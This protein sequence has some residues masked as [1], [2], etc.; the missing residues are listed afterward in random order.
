MVLALKVC[1]LKQEFSTAEP[2][3]SYGVGLQDNTSAGLVKSLQV[4]D[5]S[6]WHALH[7]FAHLQLQLL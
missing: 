6:E 3:C 7:T 5:L 1:L 4:H 2:L